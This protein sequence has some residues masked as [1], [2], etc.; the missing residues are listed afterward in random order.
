MENMIL[1]EFDIVDILEEKVLVGRHT[2]L[3]NN[4]I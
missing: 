3:R 2:N 4:G 1:G